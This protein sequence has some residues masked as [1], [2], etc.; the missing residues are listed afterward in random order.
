MYVQIPDEFSGAKL[1]LY[2]LL[3]TV[4]TPESTTGAFDVS[5]LASGVY[6]MRIALP[7][8]DLVWRSVVVGR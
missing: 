4:A 1:T 8:G 7:N 6:S 3:G 2:T 5:A